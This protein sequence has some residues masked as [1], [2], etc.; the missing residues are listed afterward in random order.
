M[1]F[2]IAVLVLL[3]LFGCVPGKPKEKGKLVLVDENAVDLNKAADAAGAQGEEIVAGKDI[4][5]ANREPLEFYN[6]L[7]VKKRKRQSFEIKLA[8]E[9]AAASQLIPAAAGKK[10]EIDIVEHD[11]KIKTVVKQVSPQAEGSV[12]F[13]KQGGFAAQCSQ[14]NESLN[15]TKTDEENV[16]GDSDIDFNGLKDYSLKFVRA[17]KIAERDCQR[18]R[19]EV[20][21]VN[22][23][24]PRAVGLSSD[25]PAGTNF[26]SEFCLDNEHGFTLGEMVYLAKGGTKNLQSKTTAISV[27]VPAAPEA[28]K[29]PVDFVPEKIECAGGKM[30]IFFLGLEKS[31]SAE[32]DIQIMQQKKGGAETGTPIPKKLAL[33]NIKVGRS[34]NREVGFASG[35]ISENFD[36][37]KVCVGQNCVSGP[38]AV[39]SEQVEAGSQT[40]ETLERS[41][42]AT[43]E[44][45]PPTDW[46]QAKDKFGATHYFTV[47]DRDVELNIYVAFMDIKVSKGISAETTL[48]NFTEGVKSKISDLN[49]FDLINMQNRTLNGLVGNELI[50]TYLYDAANNVYHKAKTFVTIKGDSGI[51]ITYSARD[52][53]YGYYL[54]DAEKALEE[55]KITAG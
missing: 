37:A 20:T 7:R 52:D 39:S 49:K 54:P 43:V 23:V 5:G 29:A 50:Y 15:C 42:P 28:V 4:G 17:E 35:E 55:T 2:V 3:L 41:L 24:K 30:K 9:I 16:Q 18:F 51:E 33:T 44:F 47:R 22:I 45:I 38:C 13:L 53:K 6:E 19:L 21:A 1:R 34:V 10:F 40:A 8:S 46:K 25:L 36:E 11:K 27:S 14:I 32:A 48:A 31:D 12:I 26:I